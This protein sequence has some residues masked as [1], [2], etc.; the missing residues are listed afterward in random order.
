[1]I[2]HTHRYID[3]PMRTR[4][5]TMQIHW[6]TIQTH[7][8]T[9]TLTH[10]THWLTDTL[11]HQTHWLTMQTHWLISKTHSLSD[12]LSHQ[13]HQM[14]QTHWLTDALTHRHVDS[15]DTDSPDS[16]CRHTD[17]PHTLTQCR[18]NDSP[19][20]HNDSP[21]RHTDSPDTL[22]LSIRFVGPLHIP[23]HTSRELR[24]PDCCQSRRRHRETPDR[25]QHS[26]RAAADK[27]R[28]QTVMTWAQTLVTREQTLMTW[29]QTLMTWG[30]RRLCCCRVW[31]C[32]RCW[33]GN[34]RPRSPATHPLL[35]CRPWRHLAACHT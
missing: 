14:S 33:C 10:Q 29:V 19:C 24:H 6:L 28:T 23:R 3:S 22:S 9:H 5:L 31:P 34:W 17:S 12:M 32:I 30:R 27:R 18:H 15:P 7:W 13:T 2:I 16:L 8:L 4:C 11:T 35:C 20:R 1:M 25:D 26:V 21:R